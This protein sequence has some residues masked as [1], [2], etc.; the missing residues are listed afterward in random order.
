MAD[1]T[2]L[3]SVLA[4]S[5]VWVRIPSS[6]P[7]KTQFSRNFCVGEPAVGVCIRYARV[8][9]ISA[10]IRVNIVEA[11]LNVGDLNVFTKNAPLVYNPPFVPAVRVRKKSMSEKVTL[12]YCGCKMWT[13]FTPAN[14][15][16]S[17]IFLGLTTIAIPL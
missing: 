10:K 6:A 2:D 17:E 9:T 3:K 12:G 8:I 4:K 13:A 14:S 7:L 11:A 1:A 16:I 5:E 15:E